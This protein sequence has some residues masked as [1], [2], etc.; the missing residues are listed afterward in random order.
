MYFQL[1]LGPILLPK[2]ILQSLF[3]NV[4]FM[5]RGLI[6]KIFDFL[7]F[8]ADEYLIPI[9]YSKYQIITYSYMLDTNYSV[10]SMMM[11][12]FQ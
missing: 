5:C 12:L 1:K 8:K 9:E 2:F 3:V 4:L 6:S 7:L 11:L 10:F